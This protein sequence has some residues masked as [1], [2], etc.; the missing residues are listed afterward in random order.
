M[1]RKILFFT[2]VLSSLSFGFETDKVAHFGLSYAL[3]ATTYGFAKKG[4]G[5]GRIPALIFATGTTTMLGCFKEA[6]DRKPELS[7]V[8]ANQAGIGLFTFQAVVYE[9]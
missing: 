1:C 6:M 4:L 9:F 5:L 2:L 8:L 3:T 7:D